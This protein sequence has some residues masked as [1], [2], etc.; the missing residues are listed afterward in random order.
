MSD[1]VEREDLY[2]P[3]RFEQLRDAG[4][5]TLQSVVVPVEETLAQFSERFA[6]LRAA[7]R[8]GF[9]I[10][11][12]EAGSGKSTFLDTV[13]IFRA[14]VSTV[15]I[16]LDADIPSELQAL[17]PTS[18]ARVIVI[19]GR[20]ALTDVSESA[21]EASLHGINGFVRAANGQNTLVVWPTNTDELTEALVG[22]GTRLGGAALMS[23]MPVVRFS[24]PPKSDYVRIAANTIAALNE[25]AS[26][27]ALGLTEDAATDLAA[28][29]PTVGDYMGSIR[30]ALL[31]NGAAVRR[32]MATEQ[33]R[34]WTVVVAGNDPEG[35]VAALTRGALSAA[36][37]D[38]LLTATNANVVNDIR[39][40]PDTIGILGT[41]LD[42]KIF[43]LE[44]LAA[45]EIARSFASADL[46]TRMT[47]LGMSTRGNKR[48]AVDRLRSSAIG[49]ILGGGQLGPR[50][51]GAEQGRTLSRPTQASH[52][53]RRRMTVY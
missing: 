21:L 20:E 25:G 50:R 29:A 48:D 8:G 53:S 3:D 12:G 4:E 9:W 1:L 16:P 5:G 26:L 10:I 14:G 49:V 28:Q 46:K 2:V 38:R 36:D 45:L 30:A 44:I 19:E 13:G 32:L 18:N 7:R 51:R 23:G 24:G 11:R 27:T 31:Q 41:V 15:R 35:D 34:V 43:H 47:G 6:D 37:I 17:P 42:A 52:L 39:A 40:Q 22:L 33:P